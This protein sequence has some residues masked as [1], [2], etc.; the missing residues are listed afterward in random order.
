VSERQI[1]GH[2]TM[3]FPNIYGRFIPTF[4][5]DHTNISHLMSNSFG[6]FNAQCPIKV[7]KNLYTDEKIS[8]VSSKFCLV[9]YQWSRMRHPFELL[10]VMVLFA[11]GF[12]QCFFPSGISTKNLYPLLSLLCMLYGPTIS[13]PLFDLSNNILWRVMQLET[14][15]RLLFG[16]ITILQVVTTI[17]YH[18][19]T[20]L[21]S[22]HANPFSLSPVVFVYSVSLSLKHLN[23]L[24]LFFTY[25]LPMTVSYRKM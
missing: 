6:R 5:R 9:W 2:S 21:H 23:S 8:S 22:L 18:T 1:I 4:T 13:F 20:Y 11:L 7:R 17:T 15:F 14:P 3:K 16:F 12:P 19:L 24:Q 25:E 10:V